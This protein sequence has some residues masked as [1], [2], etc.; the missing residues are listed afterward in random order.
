MLAMHREIGNEGA[1]GG[2][3]ASGGATGGSH[4]DAGR[5]AERATPGHGMCA[6]SGEGCTLCADQSVAE[7]GNGGG[8]HRRWSRSLGC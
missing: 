5:T 7:C 2:G 6:E 4:A 1:K 8:G 3:D